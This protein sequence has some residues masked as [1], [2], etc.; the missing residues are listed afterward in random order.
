MIENFTI[1]NFK[2]WEVL[3]LRNLKRINLITG[4]NMSGKTAL[5]D[6]L[7][8][9]QTGHPQG[10]LSAIPVAHPSSHP[11]QIPEYIQGL[12]HSLDE[13]INLNGIEFRYP[14]E[15]IREYSFYGRYDQ[16]YTQN[17]LAVATGKASRI[18]S[19]V[20]ESHSDRV[21][22][23]GL[24][25]IL[26]DLLERGVLSEKVQSYL[27]KRFYLKEIPLAPYKPI[28]Y[29]YE[30]SQGIIDIVEIAEAI[31][32][33]ISFKEVPKM[34]LIEGLGN[35]L[36]HSKIPP[37][38]GLIQQ[39]ALE[40]DFQVFASTQS[41]D[42]VEHVATLAGVSL[43]RTYCKRGKYDAVQ[44]NAETLAAAVETDVELR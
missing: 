27:L 41:R 29:Q 11:S 2:C 22:M 12:Y 42:T 15:L 4:G 33:L 3:T 36:H 28:K 6:A 5:L 34:L 23:E 17:R 40:H 7:A 10:C 37:L 9:Y 25:N 24:M 44:F 32:W 19:I 26:A 16:G 31:V 30:I 38:I 8:L 39:Y 35:G 43:I 1:T 21:R 18:G 13:P 14:S 20:S